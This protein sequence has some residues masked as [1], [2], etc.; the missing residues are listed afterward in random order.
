MRVFLTLPLVLVLGLGAARADFDAGMYAYSTG[1]YDDAAREFRACADRGETQGAYY[2][3]LL[4]EEGQGVPQDFQQARLWYG[5]AADQGDVDAAFAL[6]RL[7]SR[8]LGVPQ[9]RPLA[10]QW[11]ARAAKGGHYLGKQ[12]MTKCEGRMAPE[13]LRPARQLAAMQ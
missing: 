13:Q 3:G 9:N 6:G 11:Y 8:G 1:N 4:Y 5:K 10:Y 12:E 7:Y 2:V